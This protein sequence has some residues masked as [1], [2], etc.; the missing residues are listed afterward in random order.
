[1]WPDLNP[2][3]VPQPTL[4]VSGAHDFTW[5][6]Q[7]AE[8]LAATMPQARHVALPWAGHLPSLERPAEITDLLLDVLGSSRG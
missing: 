5:F 4:V 6:T 7:I 2:E 1:V 8:H 3:L